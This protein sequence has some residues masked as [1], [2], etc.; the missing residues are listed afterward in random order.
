MVQR[1]RFGTQP[2]QTPYLMFILRGSCSN[3][4]RTLGRSVRILSPRLQ[5]LGN[6]FWR[7]SAR[8]HVLG[9]PLWARFNVPLGHAASVVIRASGR[10]DSV[11]VEAP[12]FHIDG[13]PSMLLTLRKPCS[14]SRPDVQDSRWFIRAGIS[15]MFP[16]SSTTSYITPSTLP[17][18]PPR[19]T[20]NTQTFLPYDPITGKHHKIITPAH[21][22][23]VQKGMQSLPPPQAKGNPASGNKL[24]PIQPALSSN[25]APKKDSST[26]KTY[27]I[28]Q[29]QPP[30]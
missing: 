2:W 24:R 28:V 23:P 20:K 30:R 6:R 26:K 25:G 19:S 27:T 5:S 29:W 18:M 21:P 17:T 22:T 16:P 11:S 1:F 4:T 3:R 15:G 12:D 10:V 7:T 13:T 8:R 14:I 9:C